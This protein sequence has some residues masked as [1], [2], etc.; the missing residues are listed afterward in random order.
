LEKLKIELGR[1]KGGK[2]KKRLV[3]E[4]YEFSLSFST[5]IPYTQFLE[6]TEKK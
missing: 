5:V 6:K 4:L 3:I 2:I 1:K